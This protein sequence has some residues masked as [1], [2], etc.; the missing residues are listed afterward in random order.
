MKAVWAILKRDL[1][2]A[3]RQGGGVGTAIGFF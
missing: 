2:L 3:W 1:V